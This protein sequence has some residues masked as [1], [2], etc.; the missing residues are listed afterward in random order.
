MVGFGND[1]HG[2]DDRVALVVQGFYKPQPLFQRARFADEIIGAVLGLV[3]AGIIF[4][5]VL[6]ILDSFFRIPGV[7][8]N[9]A[10]LPFLREFWAD[11]T[12]RKFADVFRHTVIPD[13]FLLTGL[14]VPDRTR[15]STPAPERLRPGPPVGPDAGR[16]PGAHRHPPGSR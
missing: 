5:A 7:P 12:A 3:E 16:G 4:G 2:I 6:I 10:E 8:T 11:S 13:F 15:P 9:P 14:F 1:L